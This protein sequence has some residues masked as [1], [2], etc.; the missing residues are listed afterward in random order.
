VRVASAG[1]RAN[2]RRMSSA[3]FLLLKAVRASDAVGVQV[4]LHRNANP[5]ALWAGNNRTPLI[6]AASLGHVRNME[7][8]VEHNAN[9]NGTDGSR[10][11]PIYF[12]ASR[13][14]LDA[15]S[16]LAARGADVNASST[17]GRSPLYA[18]AE[19]NHVA[20]VHLLCRLGGTCVLFGFLERARDRFR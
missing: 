10:R 13:N 20:A 1:A 2:H 5:N 15:I 9:V 18:A 14:Q 17:T 8:L 16:F 6:V 4:A 12:A 11:T 7:L 19:G 3:E